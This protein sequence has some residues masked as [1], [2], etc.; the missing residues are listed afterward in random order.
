MALHAPSHHVGLADHRLLR[1]ALAAVLIAAVLLLVIGAAFVIR[2]TLPTLGTPMDEG[3]ALVQFRAGER[4]SY[5]ASQTTEGQ[6]I[7]LYRADERTGR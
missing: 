5:I 6:S 1:D 7:L 2:P 4:A 3:A